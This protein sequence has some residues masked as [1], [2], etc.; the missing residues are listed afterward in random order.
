MIDSTVL[1]ER[2]PIEVG[3]APLDAFHRE[4]RELLA[5]LSTPEGADYGLAL[6][7]MHERLLRQCAAEESWMRDAD[8]PA[9]D[10]HKREH[11]DLLEVV[12]EVRRRYDAGDNEIA[13]RFAA[14][15]PNWFDNHAQ[16]MDAALAFYL[17]ERT[18][19]A[20]SGELAEEIA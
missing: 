12:S 5:A 6:V 9:Y 10:P 17:R 8:F 14:A 15:L 3:F 2:P 4:A 13:E 20:E 18:A 1:S 19:P 11:D 16:S 7:S